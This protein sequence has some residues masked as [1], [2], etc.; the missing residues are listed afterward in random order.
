MKLSLGEKI[1][2]WVNTKVGT[3]YFALFCFLLVTIPIIFPKSYYIVFYISSGY[4]QLILLPLIIIG[5]NIQTQQAEKLAE[6]HY[7]HL[8]QVEEKITRLLK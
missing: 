8:L 3:I 6:D 5:G 4:L 7:K 1:A 2:V